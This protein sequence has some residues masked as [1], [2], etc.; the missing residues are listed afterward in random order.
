ME[1]EGPKKK[2]PQFQLINESGIVGLKK[3]TIVIDGP[4]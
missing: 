2:C 4:T 3:N 1:R